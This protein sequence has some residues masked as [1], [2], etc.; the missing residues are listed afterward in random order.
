MEDKEMVVFIW[1]W[2]SLGVRSEQLNRA[3]TLPRYGTGLNPKFIRLSAGS[4]AL[5]TGSED[6]GIRVVASGGQ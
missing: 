4:L 1:N 2:W 5:Y 3:T 6:P